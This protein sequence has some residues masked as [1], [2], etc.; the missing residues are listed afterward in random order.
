MDSLL[1]RPSEKLRRMLIQ[2][3][4]KMRSKQPEHWAK[5]KYRRYAKPYTP[6]ELVLIRGMEKERKK[7]RREEKKRGKKKHAKK[8]KTKAKKKGKKAK[9]KGAI[10]SKA[11]KKKGP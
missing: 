9:K 5:T 7:R 1:G 3:E 8:S 11:K 6:E 4:L 10:K 2:E